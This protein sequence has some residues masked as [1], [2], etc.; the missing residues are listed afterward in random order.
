MR[1][2]LQP[3]DAVAQ[4][5]GYDVIRYDGA[6][7]EDIV[8]ALGFEEGDCVIMAPK[9]IVATASVMLQ[10]KTGELAISAPQIVPGPRAPRQGPPP[11]G[12]QGYG[13]SN[14]RQPDE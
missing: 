11:T 3:A 4:F 10:L 8:Q 6:N 5:T 9:P 7:P 14:A 1:E 13:S 2:E 12:P